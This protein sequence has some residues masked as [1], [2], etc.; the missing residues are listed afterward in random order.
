[1]V[2]RLSTIDDKVYS[3]STYKDQ[4]TCRYTGALKGKVIAG[5]SLEWNSDWRWHSTSRKETMVR[6]VEDGVLLLHKQGEAIRNQ[7]RHLVG[8]EWHRG[9]ELTSDGG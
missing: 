8:D 7:C 9:E 3:E 2:A 4:A 1:L 5:F 6:K